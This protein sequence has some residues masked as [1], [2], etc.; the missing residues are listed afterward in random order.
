MRRRLRHGRHG[1]PRVA[2]HDAGGGE[3]KADHSQRPGDAALHGG[4][5]QGRLAGQPHS[6][7]GEARSSAGRP[8]PLH[9]LR[10]PVAVLHRLPV[11]R[12]GGG[13]LLL[14]L[15]QGGGD[16]AA[17]AAQRAGQC[18]AGRLR[19][20]LS[21]PQK[22]ALLRAVQLKADQPRGASRR[23]DGPVLADQK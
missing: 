2:V 9:R 21:L 22:L 15:A 1:G 19:P 17:G 3:A 14:Q 10:Q 5:V 8:R 12:P 18:A 13:H 23:L 4:R 20:R 16:A 7:H 11:R 6:L